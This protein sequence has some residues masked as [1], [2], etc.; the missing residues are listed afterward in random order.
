MAGSRVQVTNDHIATHLNVTVEAATKALQLLT[1]IEGSG[2]TRIKSLNGNGYEYRMPE[3]YPSRLGEMRNALL[4][5]EKREQ[6]SRRRG[7]LTGEILTWIREHPNKMP[8]SIRM[9]AEEIEADPNSVANCLLKL[10]RNGFIERCPIQSGWYQI[11]AMH[12]ELESLTKPHDYQEGSTTLAEVLSIAKPEP[13]ASGYALTEPRSA[14][15]PYWPHIE[16]VA[17]MEDGFVAKDVNTAK[18]YR[19]T[20]L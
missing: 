2:L 14:R 11:P 17:E 6:D 20:E 9:I 15:V 4:R 12:D 5:D 3:K 18:A 13:S 10:S 7:Q 8:A 16:I 19:V 1:R